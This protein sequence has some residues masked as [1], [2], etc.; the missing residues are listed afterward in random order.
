MWK[1]EKK[2]KKEKIMNLS[3]PCVFA[4]CVSFPSNFLYLIIS[5][6]LPNIYLKIKVTAVMERTDHRL[7]VS[8]QCLW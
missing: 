1:K 5:L 6:N 2:K 4:W 8:W 7:F 3:C